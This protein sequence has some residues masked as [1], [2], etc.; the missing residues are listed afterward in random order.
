MW[1]TDNGKKPSQVVTGIAVESRC[2]WSRATAKVLWCL[3]P[4]PI[5]LWGRF[6]RFIRS[7]LLILQ[8]LNFTHADVETHLVPL[9]LTLKYP[10][11]QA[12]HGCHEEQPGF[13]MLKSK[14]QSCEAQGHAPSLDS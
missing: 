10:E 5:D 14:A 2:L 9:H 3:R 13:F 1:Q 11:G 7:R 6:S 4:T 8:N 12:A